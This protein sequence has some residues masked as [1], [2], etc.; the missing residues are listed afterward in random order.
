[1]PCTVVNSQ[2]VVKAQQPPLTQTLPKSQSQWSQFIAQLQQWYQQLQNPPAQANVIPPDLAL[3]RVGAA[4]FL[5]GAL[6]LSNTT[7]ALDATHTYYGSNSLLVAP[8]STPATVTLTGYPIPLQQGSRWYCAFSIYSTTN[9]TGSLAV[10]TSGG[11]T[12]TE[13]FSITGTAGWQQVWCLVDLRAYTDPT[14]T[15]II[16]FN[17]TGS[18][19]IDGLQ[20]CAVGS[21]FSVPPAFQVGQAFVQQNYQ[22]TTTGQCQVEGNVIA[23][24]GGAN[25]WDSN[26]AGPSFR[27]GVFVSGRFL[28][29]SANAHMLG[30]TASPSTA[31]YTGANFAI[32]N[33]TGTINIYES[34]SQVNGSF[35]TITDTDV[36]EIRYDGV[37]VRYFKNGFL[38]RAVRASGLT[39][40]PAAYI[41]RANTSVLDFTYGAVQDANQN[42]GNLLPNY[43]WVPGASGTQGNFSDNNGATGAV[44]G[45]VIL[46]TGAATSPF[47]PYGAS[48]PLWQGGGATGGGWDG[49]WYN[50]YN[51]P[52]DLHG[53]DPLKTY[54]WS[55]WFRSH[56]AASTGLV[57]FGPDRGHNYTRRISPAGFETN[58]YF[59]YVN[60]S[61]L[62]PD[63][64]YL[65]TGIMHGYGYTGGQSGVSGIYDPVTGGHAQLASYGYVNGSSVAGASDFIQASG[66]T[67]QNMFCAVNGHTGGSANLTYWFARPR[68]EEINGNEP[69]IQAMLAPAAQAALQYL[70]ATGTAQ[71]TGTSVTKVG[72]SASWDS[73]AYLAAQFSRGCFV[74]GRVG[75]G[76]GAAHF[77]LS[78]NPASSTSYTNVDF[79]FDTG[80][81]SSQNQTYLYEGAT[82]VAGPFTTAYGDQFEVRYDGVSVRYFQNGAL[83]RVKNAPGL[84]LSPNFCVYN[85]GAGFYDIDFGPLTDQA[86]STGNILPNYSWVVGATGSQGN[87]GDIQSQTAGLITLSGNNSAPQG[88]FG[89]SEVIWKSTGGVSGG[90]GGWNNTADLIGMDP[91]KTYRFSVWVNTDNGGGGT[92]DYYLG[93]DTAGNTVNLDG[94]A[95][96]NPYFYN[97]ALSTLTANRWYLLVGILHGS[98]Y[99]STSSGQSGTWD[100]TTGTRVAAGTDFKFS[101][102]STG[103]QTHRT[104]QYYSTSASDHVYFCRPRVD[105]ING[106]EPSIRQFLAAANLD[107]IPDG[108]TYGRPLGSRLSSGKPW[109]D[110]SEG[111]H[112]NKNIDNVGDGST[113][114]RP[115]GSRLSSGKPWIDFSEGIHANKNI[116]NVGDGTTYG[117]SKGISLRTGIPFAQWS[118]SANAD[119]SH[120]SSRKT[121]GAAST[122]DT[123]AFTLIGYTSCYVAA[124]PSAT[125]DYCMVG[126]STTPTANTSFNNNNYSWYNEGGVWQLYEGGTQVIA[127]AG[128]VSLTDFVSITY[129]GSNVRYYLNGTLQHTTALS[130]ATLYGYCAFYSIGAAWN[131]LQIGAGNAVPSI[132]LDNQITEGTYGR[133]LSAR[134][135]SGK[136]WIDFSE[137]IH[138][139]KNID[140]V[141]D[142]STYARLLTSGLTSGKIDPYKGGVK[143]S[144]SFVST[145]TANV[146]N[147]TYT[148]N[149]TSIS[150]SWGAFTLYRP[151]GTT[152]AVG[153]GAEGNCT[154]LAAGTIY[155]FYPYWPETA[156][157][158]T[159]VS[160]GTG[161]GS[162]AI[163]YTT[164]G[165][166]PVAASTMFGQANCALGSF[167]ASTT[168]SG[169]GSGSGGGGGCPHPNADLET[170]NRGLVKAGMLEVGDRLYTPSGPQAIRNITR[171]PY[172]GWIVV[173]TKTHT[174]Q[175]HKFVVTPDHRFLDPEGRQVQALEL[176]VGSLLDGD[177]GYH[178]VVGLLGLY[179]HAACV[180]LELEAPH[181]Y[182]SRRGGILCHNVK[183]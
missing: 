61:A 95:N 19:W 178:R 26:A 81:G 24:V 63:K 9:L 138:A 47:G 159:F 142:G 83:L 43:S 150:I 162:P 127:N 74:K 168:S 15:W 78:K 92:G 54:R 93:C 133:P 33:S 82:Q 167:L 80:N 176:R 155:K 116:D 131:S 134:L 107:A 109:I 126:F 50:S 169:S 5:P 115:L 114:A 85:P 170:E 21:T 163:A 3:F 151:D 64:W 68:V 48:E 118:A 106:N 164:A 10:K 182:Y 122:W 59:V 12:I 52:G 31:S 128:T 108:T 42:T 160:G 149:T 117:R 60:L 2:S 27:N 6:T 51:S 148:N 38:L 154:L 72:G 146:T 165:G 91:T 67:Q 66:V 183:P 135:S 180:S 69:S 99:G 36:A 97:A 30:L 7:A 104:Y 49:G 174:G 119:V 16:T 147:F 98:G 157:P 136:P 17:Q 113:Y 88:P 71:V 102:T 22:F 32:Y 87:F 129:D 39:L 53:I 34:G 1:M 177:H 130:G 4:S 46:G 40:A 172:T 18:Y 132:S 62:V 20:M 90:N 44:A 141:G 166:D 28:A 156:G 153:A 101:T 79:A 179:T 70:T 14:A 124:K 96:S 125:S 45:Q 181:V 173:R 65:L 123:T 76:N 75:I 152:T 121:G 89:H 137:G 23:K 100:P 56:Q 73:N 144:G 41:W 111:I 143:G 58:G 171:R 57:Y 103:T 140:N 55:V 13:T 110:F 8:S 11:H 120:E 84:A 77:G 145:I 175:S 35:G 158:V 94:T 37:I 139:N 86:Q 29:A 105:E 25:T 161:T 112:A